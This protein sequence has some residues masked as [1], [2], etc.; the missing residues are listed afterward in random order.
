MKLFWRT[1]FYSLLLLL[2]ACS[3]QDDR[4]S[5]RNVWSTQVDAL[6][7]ARGVEQVLQKGADERKKQIDEQSQ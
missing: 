6:K 7:K 5:D 2:M 1:L 4:T 3:A